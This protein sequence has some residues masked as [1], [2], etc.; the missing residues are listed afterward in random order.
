MHG[1]PHVFHSI[2]PFHADSV[3]LVWERAAPLYRSLLGADVTLSDVL[4]PYLD[5]CPPALQTGEGR[6]LRGV[7]PAGLRAYHGADPAPPDDRRTGGTGGPLRVLIT[8]GTVSNDAIEGLAESARHLGRRGAEVVMTLGPRGWFDWSRATGGG[9]GG[10][11]GGSVRSPDERVRV[12]DYVPLGAELPTT[13]VLIHHGGSNTTRAAIEHGVPMLVIPQGAEQYRNA[14]WIA[15]RG[16][17]R[18]MMPSDVTPAAVVD[19]VLA[20]AGDPATRERVAAARAAWLAMPGP[21]EV[22]AEVERCA[23]GAPVGGTV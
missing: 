3:A 18:M 20:L 19:C 17:G 13:S 2:G 5:V 9:G 23:A 15:E 6:A 4:T 14:C 7:L 8:F 11:R 21:G 12:V 1:L 10:G 16:L 22:V